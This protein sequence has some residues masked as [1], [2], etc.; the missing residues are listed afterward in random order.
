[1][2][3]E[4][5][6]ATVMIESFMRDETVEELEKRKKEEAEKAALAA[7][8]KKK[9]P[10]GKEEVKEEGPVKVRDV[11]MADIVVNE[12]MLPEGRWIGSQLQLIK[13]RNICDIYTQ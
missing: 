4:K 2:S 10:K 1:M 6:I 7:K 13:Q 5:P 8:D 12:G 3:E 9:A 11:E